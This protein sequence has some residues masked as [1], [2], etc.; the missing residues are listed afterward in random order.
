MA[1]KRNDDFIVGL[2]V[3]AATVI[4]VV[5]AMWVQQV[6]FR[7]RQNPVQA[8]FRDVG[9]TTVGGAVVVRGV[10]SGRI[11]GIE[12]GD[13]GW[14]NVRLRL[15]EGVK[16]PSDPVVLLS[17]A[18]LFGEWQATIVGRSALPPNPDVKRQVAESSGDPGVLPGASL[19]DVAQLTAVA[20]RIADDVASLADRVQ[21][22][23]D[24]SAASELRSSIRDVSEMSAIL[25]ETVRRQSQNLDAITADVGSGVHALSD[26]AETV[27]R[28]AERI[29]SSTASGQVRSVVDNAAAASEELRDAAGSLRILAERL[30]VSQARIDSV[31]VSSNSLV[32]KLDSGTGSL[33]LLV[34]DPSL[35]QQTDSLVRQLR[36]LLADFQANP[37]RYFGLRIF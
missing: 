32:A 21:T 24:D 37:K 14:V 34:N 26:A 20:G 29:D 7:H 33:G 28:V 8:R 11:T 36:V 1:S 2:V 5:A 10:N 13:D 4:I 18:S 6:D 25:A 19:P 30:S 9:N 15:D 31:L 12:L 22:A 16:L 3:V 17:Q 35:Y 23:F 27:Q